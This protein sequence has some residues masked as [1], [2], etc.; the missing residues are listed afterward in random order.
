MNWYLLAKNIQTFDLSPGSVVAVVMVFEGGGVQHRPGA[1]R[2]P[3]G[4]CS[5][6]LFVTYRPDWGFPQIFEETPAAFP[7]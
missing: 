2:A 7:A 3:T 5:H 6:M 4:C 1:P